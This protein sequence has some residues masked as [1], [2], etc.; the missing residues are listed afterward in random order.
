MAAIC[1]S[2]FSLVLFGFGDGD[3]SSNFNDSYSEACDTVFR[4]RATTFICLTWFT[5]LLA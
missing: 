2:A 5:L 1:L 3:L 4:A